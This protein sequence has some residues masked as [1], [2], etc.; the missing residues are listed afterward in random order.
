MD[1]PLYS[2]Y[3]KEVENLIKNNKNNAIHA[4]LSDIFLLSMN[5]KPKLIVELG[6]SSSAL[7]NKVLWRIADLFDADFISCDISDFSNVCNYQDWHFYQSDDIEFSSNFIKY[8]RTK[9]I[10]EKIDILLIDTDEKY[11]HTKYEIES[12]F[13]H[14]SKKCTIFFRCTNLKPLLYYKNGT[15]TDLGWDNQRGVIKAVEEFFNTTF[16]ESVLFEATIDN[17]KIIHSPY[18]AGLTTLIRN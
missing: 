8:C 7:A 13:P 16:D 14:L 3:L 17:W 4:S 1:Y 9:K 12:W 2:N 5:A 15:V 18:G 11:P 10:R 6:V